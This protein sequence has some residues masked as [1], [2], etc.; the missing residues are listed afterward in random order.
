MNLCDAGRGDA[1][2]DTEA[3]ARLTCHL[4][5]RLFKTIEVPQPALYSVGQYIFV[6]FRKWSVSDVFNYICLIYNYSYLLFVRC[7]LN[8]NVVSGT[9]PNPVP[10][11]SVYNIKLSCD[12]HL[13]AAAHNNIQVGPVLAVLKVTI[14][15]LLPVKFMLWK[16]QPALILALKIMCY[17][18]EE[19]SNINYISTV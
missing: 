15:Q 2:M 4:L 6:W 19:V 11:N 7:M 10:N 13:L 16:N 18:N 9:S 5:L 1:D 8:D 3:G 12:R 17:K 14:S